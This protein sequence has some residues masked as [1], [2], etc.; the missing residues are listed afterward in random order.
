MT[1]NISLVMSMGHR[2]LCMIEG[3]V[4]MVDTTLTRSKD[5]DSKY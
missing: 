5:G 1:K 3:V 2:L 4:D